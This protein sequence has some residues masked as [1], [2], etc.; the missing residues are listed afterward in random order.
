M[1]KGLL[2]TTGLLASSLLTPGMASTI[3][4]YGGSSVENSVLEVDRGLASA[5]YKPRK[6][7]PVNGVDCS[8]E[9]LYEEDVYDDDGNVIG[10]LVGDFYDAK[11]NAI[12][13][14]AEYN[15]ESIEEGCEDNEKVMVGIHI[16]MEIY[17]KEIGRMIREKAMVR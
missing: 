7:K 6:V 14:K 16:T 9:D 11:D 3:D 5:I 12:G 17:T 15:S 8:V 13:V 1:N 10:K 2:I 4:E